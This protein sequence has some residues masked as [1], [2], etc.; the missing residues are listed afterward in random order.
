MN[1]THLLLLPF[2][3]AVLAHAAP[4]HQPPA[5]RIPDL[6]ETLRHGRRLNCADDDAGLKLALKANDQTKAYVAFVAGCA[7]LPS[8]MIGNGCTNALTAKTA[9]Q[10]C[11]ETC[12]DP[13]C[14]AAEPALANCSFVAAWETAPDRATGTTIAVSEEKCRLHDQVFIPSGE[15]LTLS[16][17]HKV[18]G[19]HPRPVITGE[20]ETRLFVLHGELTLIDLILEKGQPNN[21]QIQKGQHYD[22]RQYHFRNGEYVCINDVDGQEYKLKKSDVWCPAGTTATLRASLTEEWAKQHKYRSAGV[23][24]L[25]GGGIQIGRPRNA[26][27]NANINPQANGNLVLR[28]SDVRKCAL[29]YKNSEFVYLSA[30]MATEEVWSTW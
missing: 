21:Q 10:Y 12:E 4:Q 5:S 27:R 13:A 29:P 11:P 9:T 3:L 7:A 26:Y 14:A 28:R 15:R 30:E 6:S 20:L 1:Q 2:F 25:T 22:A 17:T 8:L 16:G 19:G 24:T 23:L 18:Q